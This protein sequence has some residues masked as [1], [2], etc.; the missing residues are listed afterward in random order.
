MTKRE[1][2]SFHK[3]QLSSAEL[4]YEIGRQIIAEA[5]QSKVEHTR[6]LE[7]LGAKPERSPRAKKVL[8]E[9]KTMQLIGNLTRGN[10]ISA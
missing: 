7:K 10:D 6:A 1:Q 8:S 5:T 3:K 9:Q 4:R 2:I